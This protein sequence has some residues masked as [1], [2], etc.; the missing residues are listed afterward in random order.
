VINI[1][2]KRKLRDIGGSIM[3]IIPKD[4]CTYLNLNVEDEVIIREDKGKHGK[5]IS[6]WKENQ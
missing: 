2:F 4:L 1:E 6:F 5:F 3:L